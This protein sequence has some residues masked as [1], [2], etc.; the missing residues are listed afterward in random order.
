MST[1]N[2]S[3][4]QYI[5]KQPTKKTKIL[6]WAYLYFLYEIAVYLPFLSKRERKESS[7]EPFYSFSYNELQHF[8][9][10]LP[11]L[12][13]PIKL[14]GR[15]RVRRAP[16]HGLCPTLCGQHFPLG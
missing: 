12:L 16:A 4:A 2:I 15:S 14:A 11:G 9:G 10:P 1:A 7:F 3:L 6:S 13:S 5:W 8:P